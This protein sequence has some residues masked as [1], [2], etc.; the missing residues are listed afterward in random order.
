MKELRVNCIY[1]GN[2]FDT[3]LDWVKTNGR[4]FCDTCCKCFDLKLD[5]VEEIDDNEATGDEW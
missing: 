3:S 5:N 1:C 2:S 4:V